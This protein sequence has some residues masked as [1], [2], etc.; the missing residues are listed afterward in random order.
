MSVV[1]PIV[2][3]PVRYPCFYEGHGAA[4]TIY[5]KLDA[6]VAFSMRKIS[7]AQNN[8]LRIRRDSDDAEIDV[9]FSGGWL[10]EQAIKDFGGYNLLSYT[11]DLTN[12][13]WLK[14]NY[15]TNGQIPVVTPNVITNPLTGEQN[16]AK[17]DFNAVDSSGVSAIR[18]VTPNVDGEQLVEIYLKTIAGSGTKR[19][20]MRMDSDQGAIAKNFDVTENWAKYS[21]NVAS[22]RTK[23]RGW[24]FRLR[25]IT[26]TDTIASVYA[27]APQWVQGSSSLPYQPRTAGRASDCF[28]TTWYGKDG[29]NATQTTEADQPKIYDFASGEVTK[30]NGKPAMVF[31]GAGDHINIPNVTGRSNIDAYFVNR[32]DNAS[33]T[34]VMPSRYLYFGRLSAG[35]YGFVGEL[36][37]TSSKLF[38]YYGNP[39]LYKNNTLFTG[40]HRGDIY[41]FLGQTQNIVNHQGASVESW[42]DLQ[43]GKYSANMWAFEGTLQEMAVFDGTL[44][45]QQRADLH[46]DIN[47]KFNIY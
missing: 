12:N 24:S 11:E 37:S 6:L 39:N 5:D 44:N 1:K 31:D 42:S 28:V 26:G 8:C 32:H 18:Q 4:P 33:T 34:S 47:N 41:N 23:V 2:T 43:F 14:E 46:A 7:L 16:A 19:L 21:I 9:G 40:T 38:S 27:Y 20:R 30:E 22:N 36:N 25:P 13:L 17:V 29:Y 15:G 35:G 10:D 45:T 3:H